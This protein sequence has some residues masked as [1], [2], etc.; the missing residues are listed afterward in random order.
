MMATAASPFTLV[1]LFSML[2]RFFRLADTSVLVAGRILT[3]GLRRTP[4]RCGLSTTSSICGGGGRA[5]TG[6]GFAS[7]E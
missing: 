4:S 5:S 3:I 2:C 7:L 6:I 1:V